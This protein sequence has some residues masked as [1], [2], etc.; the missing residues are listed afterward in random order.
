MKEARVVYTVEFSD[1][2]DVPDDW[3]C[4]GTI[5]AILEHTDMPYNGGDLLDW[6]VKES[7]RRT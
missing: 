2:I 1:S 4:D 5:E 6:E 3:E 7:R